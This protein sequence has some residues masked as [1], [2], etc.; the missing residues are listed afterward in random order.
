MKNAVD[1]IIRYKG[2]IVL[3]MRKDEP[4][5]WALPGGYVEENESMEQAAVREAKEETNL[6]IS[7]LKQLHTYSDPKRDSRHRVITT[8]YMAEGRGELKAGDD[9][10][11][12]RVFQ[13]DKVP[14]LVLDH[15][16]ILM[17]YHNGEYD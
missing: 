1:I 4:K 8:A 7:F 5:G 16:R 3:I 15:S 11:D 13:I 6:A 12:A 2:G 17:D 10:D 14:K 9:A